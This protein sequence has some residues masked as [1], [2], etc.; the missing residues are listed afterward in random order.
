VPPAILIVFTQ[1]H[2]TSTST[3]HQR[4]EMRGRNTHLKHRS[5]KLNE[6]QRVT[7]EQVEKRILANV[8]VYVDGYL[9]DTTDIELK[10][11]VTLAGGRVVCV[12]QRH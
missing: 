7:Q 4:N 9:R 8:R 2:V 3:G 5:T 1:D 11:L 10:R 6:Q 12:E